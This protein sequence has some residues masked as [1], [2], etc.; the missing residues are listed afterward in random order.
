MK[1]WSSNESCI[2]VC[3]TQCL[4]SKS[5]GTTAGKHLHPVL[6]CRNEHSALS[7]CTGKKAKNRAHEERDLT[8]EESIINCFKK[9]IKYLKYHIHILYHV[10]VS[11]SAA[12]LLNWICKLEVSE[13]VEVPSYSCS[14]QLSAYFQWCLNILIS[15][16]MMQNVLEQNSETKFP[17]LLLMQ[18]S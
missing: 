12:D 3:T 13:C 15:L 11:R 14:L 18:F 1:G 17:F 7:L 4:N 8:V 5:W 10:G 9:E 6:Q 2:P 16:Y